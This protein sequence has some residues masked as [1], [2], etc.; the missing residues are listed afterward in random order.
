L[1]PSQSRVF[2][3]PFSLLFSVLYLLKVCVHLQTNQKGWGS[4]RE[5]EQSNTIKLR[6][7][8][9]STLGQE[10]E[11]GFGRGLV[12]TCYFSLK[13]WGELL[14]VTRQMSKRG[15]GLLKRMLSSKNS[16]RNLVLEEI[17]LL[18]LKKLVRCA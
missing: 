5:T 17:G 3:L 4:E 7:V 15:R 2:S 14:V 18:F 16:L 8:I 6:F 9:I 13:R 1:N 11:L 12:A 10:K